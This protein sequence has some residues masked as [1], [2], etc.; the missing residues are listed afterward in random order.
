MTCPAGLP[1]WAELLVIVVGFGLLYLALRR[2][3]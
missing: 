3:S 1:W 2:K